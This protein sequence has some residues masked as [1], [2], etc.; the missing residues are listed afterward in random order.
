MKGGRTVF[1]AA[2]ATAV[3]QKASAILW[4]NTL[5]DGSPD[6]ST[7]H[8]ECPVVWGLKTGKKRWFLT[9]NAEVMNA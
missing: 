8:E 9:V 7:A 5:S 1:P 4:F 3:P 2:F 6:S